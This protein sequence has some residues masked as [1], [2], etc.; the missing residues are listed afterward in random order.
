MPRHVAWMLRLDEGV[1]I[2][3]VH[4]PVSC[5]EILAIFGP[6]WGRIQAATLIFETLPNK[7]FPVLYMRVWLLTIMSFLGFR[8]VIAEIIQVIE[9]PRTV[10]ITALSQSIKPWED[11]VQMWSKHCVKRL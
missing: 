3:L 4:I 2:S 11:F 8:L 9:D 7:S 6:A 10:R 1:N 5:I